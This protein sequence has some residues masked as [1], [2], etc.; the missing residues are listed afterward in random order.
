MT[1]LETDSGAGRARSNPDSLDELRAALETARALL[2]STPDASAAYLD[3]YVL[4]TDLLRQ[5]EARIGEL[6]PDA[7]ITPD[8]LASLCILL[9]PY[10]NLTTLTGS[11]LGLHPQCAVLNHAGGRI[12]PNPRL[13][14]LADYSPDRFA[15]FV[16]SAG[17]A[18]RGGARGMHGGDIR[19]SHAFD[20]E[21]MREADAKLQGS[22]GG[23]IT[24]LV[25]KESQMVSNFLRDEHV[26]VARLLDANPRI[27]FLLPIRNPIDCAISNVRRGHVRLL[28]DHHELSPSS[29]LEDVVGAVL[30]EIAIFVA[31]RESSGRTERFF[32]YFEHEMGREVLERMLR[33]V[34]LPADDAYLGAAAEAF[35]PDRAPDKDPRLFGPYADMVRRKFAGHPEIRDALLRF[36]PR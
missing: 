9:G 17:F 36:V 12:L 14:F 19:L 15:E 23:R 28:A 22:R 24:C 32:L 7:A 5:V 33:F 30:D 27:R 20:R 34:D 11:V 6:E 35:K 29:P 26:D 1:P 3:L 18:A 8:Q 10:R 31:L 4:C 2:A 21:A 13:N 25:W 16:R